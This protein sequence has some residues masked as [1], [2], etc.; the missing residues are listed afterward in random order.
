MCALNVSSGMALYHHLKAQ[1]LNDHLYTCHDCS[2][3]YNNLKEL[4][5]HQ[6]NVHCSK[7]VNCTQCDY[8]AT[9][10]A[11]M[12]QHVQRHTQ[13]LLCRKCGRSFLTLVELSHEH[14]H[15]HRDTCKHCGAEYLT[16][17][18][19]HIHVVGKYGVWGMCAQDVRKDLIHQVKGL[20][21]SLNVRLQ[22][23]CSS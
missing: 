3:S 10:K 21:T 19:L 11:K 13:G 18:S 1:H 14:L 17:A 16:S 20:D 9:S 22:T 2:N 6:S 5:L 8:T 23:P 4:S 7:F 12:C 15:N